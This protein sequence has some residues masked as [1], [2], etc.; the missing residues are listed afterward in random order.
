M[1]IHININTDPLTPKAR[2]YDHPDKGCGS[3]VD[4]NFHCGD[5]AS[6]IASLSLRADEARS[7]AQV[8]LAIADDI[9][10][11]PW[12]RTKHGLAWAKNNQGCP[13]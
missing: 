9:D 4:I 11:T 7:L 2:R 12:E 3:Y 6:A 10:A 8:M 1:A 13:E 5:R